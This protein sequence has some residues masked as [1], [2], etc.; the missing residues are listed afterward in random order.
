MLDGLPPE[1]ERNFGELKTALQR[2]FGGMHWEQQN[3]AQ[4]T[5]RSREEGESLQ[6]LPHDVERLARRAQ[7]RMPEVWLADPAIQNFI[8]ALDYVDMELY[9]R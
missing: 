2:R 4:L 7:S 1:Q 6:Q 3:R 5:C 9:V 8:D